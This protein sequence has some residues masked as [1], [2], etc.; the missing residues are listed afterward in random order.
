MAD[1]KRIEALEGFVEGLSFVVEFVIFTLFIY[2][3]AGQLMSKDLLDA[4]FQD[5]GNRIRLG[6]KLVLSPI[7]E[8]YKEF[9]NGKGI[10]SVYACNGYATNLYS[11]EMVNEICQIYLTGERTDY[12]WNGINLEDFLN[13]I[14]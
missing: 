14:S 2:E 6:K 11:L 1:N 4:I 12:T 3:E 7:L 13:S 8:S 5:D 9:F 10:L